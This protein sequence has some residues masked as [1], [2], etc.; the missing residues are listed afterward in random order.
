MKHSIF[1][2]ITVLFLFALGS[3]F[4]FSFYFLR[5]QAE[6]YAVDN[7]KQRYERVSI[8]FN[9]IIS[10]ET[11]LDAI[12]IYLKEM[13]FIQVNDNNLKKSL[14]DTTKILYDTRISLSKSANLPTQIN[15]W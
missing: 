7:E 14:L 10:K 1:F 2:K 4:A 15:H 12:Q 6:R 3:F 5:F 9:H 11:N 13:G 8:I